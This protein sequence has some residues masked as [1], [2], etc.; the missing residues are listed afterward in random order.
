MTCLSIQYTYGKIEKNDNESVE[1]DSCGGV[2][3]FAS[4]CFRSVLFEVNLPIVEPIV[5]VCVMILCY[6]FVG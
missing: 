5:D 4:E 6:I 1:G 3:V 2:L